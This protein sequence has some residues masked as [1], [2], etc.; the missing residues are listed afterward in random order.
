MTEKQRK[1]AVPVLAGEDCYKKTPQLY[2][3]KSR[4]VLQAG[5]SRSKNK[6]GASSYEEL[7]GE[8]SIAGLSPWVIENHLPPTSSQS[9]PSVWCL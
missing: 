8:G 7:E 9:L 2:G 6:Q 1:L 3:V 5:S 4:M